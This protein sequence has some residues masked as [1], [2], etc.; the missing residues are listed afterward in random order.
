MHVVT[1]HKALE[2]FKMQSHLSSRQ[3][4]WMDYLSRFYFNIRY[5]KGTSNKVVDALSLG[6][7][8][9]MGKPMIMCHRYAWVQVQV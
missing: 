5:V 1:D 4:R 9:G 8:M 6:H 2:F 7:D 3:I